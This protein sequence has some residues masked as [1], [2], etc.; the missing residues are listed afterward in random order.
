MRFINAERGIHMNRTHFKELFK[1]Y[2]NEVDKGLYKMIEAEKNMVD[3]YDK[4]KCLCYP[5]IKEM[6][7]DIFMDIF[8]IKDEDDITEDILRKR[9]HY[10]KSY[11]PL[12]RQ[13]DAMQDIPWFYEGFY[14]SSPFE[15]RT[16]LAK[17]L[18]FK[19]E[20][21]SKEEIEEE[22]RKADELFEKVVESIQ[23]AHKILEQKTFLKWE[24]KNNDGGV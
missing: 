10:K 7:T 22:K 1:L 19:K 23:Y 11:T 4:V 13:L 3:T 21:K 18:Y 16:K 17:K 8:H 20:N 12:F 2:R 6:L 5:T 15:I 9:L 14:D 24:D